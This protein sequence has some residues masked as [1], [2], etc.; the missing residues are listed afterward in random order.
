MLRRNWASLL[1]LSK[2]CNPLKFF[3]ILL[4]PVNSSLRIESPIGQIT[5]FFENRE[6]VK[7][8]FSTFIRLDYKQDNKAIDY[9]DIGA[10]IGITAAY[11]LSRNKQNMCLCFEPDPRNLDLLM[12]NMGKNDIFNGRYKVK[13]LAVHPTIT[14]THTF[15]LTL[16]RKYSSL[17]KPLRS[18]SK[19]IKVNC[20]NVNELSKIIRKELPCSIKP[21]TLKIDIEGLE[22]DILQRLDVDGL[23]LNYIMAEDDRIKGFKLRTKRK[24]DEKLVSDNVWHFYEKG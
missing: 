5:L 6:D 4:L 13:D 16:D 18:T 3:W 11:F 20:V 2:I 17:V 19:K 7:T 21:R 8:F 9:I 12:A 23:L 14:G 10:N 22:S 1:D 24:F 15:N